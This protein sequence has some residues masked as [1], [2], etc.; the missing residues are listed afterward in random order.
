M[1]LDLGEWRSSHVSLKTPAIFFALVI[2][3]IATGPAPSA[4]K[5]KESFRVA[6][7]APIAT[8]DGDRKM[9]EFW[10]DMCIEAGEKTQASLKW[11]ADQYTDCQKRCK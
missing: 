7:N 3:L 6:Q 8:C 1:S 10:R 2:A 11:C 5:G 9:C 4:G